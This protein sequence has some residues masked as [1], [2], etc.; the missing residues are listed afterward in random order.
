MSNQNVFSQIKKKNSAKVYIFSYFSYWQDVLLFW[1]VS[2][3]V[4]FLK[5][6][7]SQQFLFSHKESS[8]LTLWTFWTNFTYKGWIIPWY[9]YLLCYIS[10]RKLFHHL[11]PKRA[12]TCLNKIWLLNRAHHHHL[13]RSFLYAAAHITCSAMKTADAWTPWQCWRPKLLLLLEWVKTCG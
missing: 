1:K 10:I 2:S 9:I 3:W 8:A 5:K 12:R 13:S 4:R 7:H 6:Y 11:L